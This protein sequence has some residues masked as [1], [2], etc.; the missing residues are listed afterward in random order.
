MN[1]F[2]IEIWNTG[3]LNRFQVDV[4]FLFYIELLLQIS[5]SF[6]EDDY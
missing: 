6:L 4:G 5:L 1:S 3:P 2:A